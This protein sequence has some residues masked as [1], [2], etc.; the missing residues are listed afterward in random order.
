MQ[1]AA[2]SIGVG[3]V[4]EVE[5]AGVQPSIDDCTLKVG[6]RTGAVSVLDQGQK[7]GGI[8]DLPTVQEIQQIEIGPRCRHAT[9]PRFQ[10]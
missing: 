4:T 2:E 8:E 10:G 3:P 5:A 6:D 7:S 9:Y 1:A